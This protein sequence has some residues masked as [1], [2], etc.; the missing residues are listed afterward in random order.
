MQPEMPV[1]MT[2][3]THFSHDSLQNVSTDEMQERLFTEKGIN[4]NDLPAGF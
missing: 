1:T 2:A 3:S 4:F